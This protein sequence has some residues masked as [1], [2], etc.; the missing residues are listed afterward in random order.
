M[1]CSQQIAPDNKKKIDN[2]PSHLNAPK[3]CVTKN[4]IVDVCLVFTLEVKG[5]GVTIQIIPTAKH[6][7]VHSRALSLHLA[8]THEHP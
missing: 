6:A 3:P 8:R 4:Y 1:S 5:N 7:L 2:K